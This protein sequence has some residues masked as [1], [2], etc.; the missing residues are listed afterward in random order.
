MP[1]STKPPRWY[2]PVVDAWPVIVA[3]VGIGRYQIDHNYQQERA[4]KSISKDIET[5]TTMIANLDGRLQREERFRDAHPTGSQSRGNR[6]PDGLVGYPEEQTLDLPR[7][8]P[9]SDHLL[10][11]VPRSK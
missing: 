10:A 6:V 2:K 3:L 5:L 11:F 9:L 4:T 7:R 1:T 8:W